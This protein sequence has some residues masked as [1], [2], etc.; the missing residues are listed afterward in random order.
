MEILCMNCGGTGTSRVTAATIPY[1]REVL[2]MF[3]Q[4]VT[5]VV[6]KIVK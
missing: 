5:I 3:F 6:L 4:N 1:F 2:D